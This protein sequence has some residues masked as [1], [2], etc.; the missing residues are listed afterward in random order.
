MGQVVGISIAQ[1]NRPKVSSELNSC[2]RT[3]CSR[4]VEV[5]VEVNVGK[6]LLPGV[7]ESG[8]CARGSRD[9]LDLSSLGMVDVVSSHERDRGTLGD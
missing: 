9:L 8:V 3:I 2:S 5:F 6:G 1:P 7:L 4:E